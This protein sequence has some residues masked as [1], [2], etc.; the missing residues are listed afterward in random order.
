MDQDVCSIAAWDSSIH[1]N[2]HL[3]R[4]TEGRKIY[5]IPNCIQLIYFHIIYTRFKNKNDKLPEF[6]SQWRW[7]KKLSPEIINEHSVIK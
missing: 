2:L 5:P 6:S 7:T 3:N 1:D 4:V